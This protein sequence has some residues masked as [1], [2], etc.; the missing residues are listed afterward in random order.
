MTWPGQA[1]VEVQ[2]ALRPRGEAVVWQDASIDW[3]ELAQRVEVL[4]RRLHYL[5]GTRPRVVAVL[6]APSLRF[7]E[8]MHAAQRAGITLA[9]LAPRG[10]E[11]DWRRVL[12][13]VA[14]S[15]LLWG[16]AWGESGPRLADEFDC[17]GLNVDSGLDEAPTYSGA[18]ATVAPD[19]TWLLVH[20]SGT[21]GDP[22]GVGLRN[23]QLLAAATAVL[24]RLDARPGERWLAAMPMHHVGGLSVP[25]RAA[26]GGLSVVLHSGF[27]VAA[28]R[29]SL[30]EQSIAW[31]SLVPTMLASLLEAECAA[32]PALRAAILGGGRLPPRL[33]ERAARQGWPLVATYGMTETAAQVTTSH[34]GDAT[35]HPGSAGHPLR[36]VELRIDAP[37]DDGVGEIVVRGAQVFRGY[38]DDPRRSATVLRDGWLH[39]GDLG[40]LDADR[41]LWVETRRTDLIVSGGENVRPE[42]VEDV[43]A[44]H[45]A[46]VDC[47][48]F[49]VDDEHWGQVVT[50]ALV[51][52]T[53]APSDDELRAWCGARLARF[54][55]PRRWLRLDRL[56][57][58]A[59]GK[60][61]RHRLRQLAGG[62]GET[63]AT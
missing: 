39:T 46:I 48:V 63:T 15:L 35:Q 11:D 16:T 6:A 56:P 43:L 32:P 50:A 40:R 8:L 51:V 57:R 24:E 58:N 4:A 2:A 22:K 61:E 17:V 27:D 9:P 45:P 18:L 30:H 41:R 21:T 5:I 1:W 49:G 55:V 26:V 28:V 31:V 44:A 10:S 38:R 54:K 25:V 3:Q 33:V 19:H 23:D 13:R 52:S 60:L 29:R 42:E 7:L 20:T 12:R 62:D 53:G 59:A 36:G 14:P 47:G 34:T 37:D